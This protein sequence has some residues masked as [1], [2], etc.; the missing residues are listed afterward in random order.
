MTKLSPK[1]KFNMCVK[2]TEYS[3]NKALNMAIKLIQ[4]A[5]NCPIC[6]KWHL[7]TKTKV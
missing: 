4:R 5:Y 1:A 6:N 3:K 7:T 2:K